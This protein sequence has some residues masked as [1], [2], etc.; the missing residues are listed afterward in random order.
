MVRVLLMPF[1]GP[2]AVV[3]RIVARLRGVS[4]ANWKARERSAA[5]IQADALAGYA[6]GV[7]PLDKVWPL[8]KKDGAIALQ[9]PAR[10]VVYV[11][12]AQGIQGSGEDVLK[13]HVHNR[14]VFPDGDAVPAQWNAI[15]LREH[16]KALD[17]HMNGTGER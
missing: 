15:L 8:R 6:V 9:R 5:A 12:T 1:T 10:E 4:S 3:E 2:F 11:P 13:Y 16:E 14:N 7:G 17:E